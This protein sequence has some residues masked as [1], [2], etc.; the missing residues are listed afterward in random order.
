[1]DRIPSPLH[2]LD[3]WII[4]GSN[5]GHKGRIIVELTQLQSDVDPAVKDLCSS[6]QFWDLDDRDPHCTREMVETVGERHDVWSQL[7]LVT[8][9][10]VLVEQLTQIDG[11]VVA[12][13]DET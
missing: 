7:D 8:R 13:H 6:P 5:N 12:L 9:R 1:M 11:A 3:S 4:E 2:P 10:P